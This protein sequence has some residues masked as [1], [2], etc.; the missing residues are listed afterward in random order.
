MCNKVYCC[1]C[2]NLLI[3]GDY[4]PAQCDES[5]VIN[6]H[7]EYKFVNP[8]IKNV[9]SNCTDFVQKRRRLSFWTGVEIL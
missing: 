9:N 8:S 2:T 7:K 5:K 3:G 1:N 4:V 6:G